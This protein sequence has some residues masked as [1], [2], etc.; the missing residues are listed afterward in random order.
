MV[1][2]VVCD[3]NGGPQEPGEFTGYGETWLLSLDV[4]EIQDEGNLTRYL[5]EGDILKGGEGKVRDRGRP[6]A[7]L[8]E[9][10]E[11]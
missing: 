6:K 8:R 4:V 3:V 10:D 7:G 11:E 5:V 2:Q 1:D 9:D